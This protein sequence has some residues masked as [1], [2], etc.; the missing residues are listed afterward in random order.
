MAAVGVLEKSDKRAFF[1]DTTPLAVRIVTNRL[2]PKQNYVVSKLAGAFV[3][4]SSVFITSCHMFQEYVMQ[5]HRG[6]SQEESWEVRNSFPPFL[7]ATQ[8]YS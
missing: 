3:C 4:D 5:V 8:P 6:T 2:V 7:L 1:D